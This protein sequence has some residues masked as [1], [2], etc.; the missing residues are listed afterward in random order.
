VQGLIN[1]FPCIFDMPANRCRP[2]VDH[3]TTFICVPPRPHN[4]SRQLRKH[5]EEQIPTQESQNYEKSRTCC[6]PFSYWTK[7]IGRARLRMTSRKLVAPDKGPGPGS[8]SRNR[9]PMRNDTGGVAPVVANPTHMIFLL[10]F[11]NGLGTVH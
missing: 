10:P 5:S 7:H 3:G 1:Y 4:P 8:L 11:E 6:L 2:E 9:W